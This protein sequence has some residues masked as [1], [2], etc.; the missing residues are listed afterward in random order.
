MFILKAFDCMGGIPFSQARAIVL[1]RRLL[2]DRHK[3]TLWR[4]NGV[5][6]AIDTFMNLL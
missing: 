5:V 1:Q 3:E 6:L 2:G 4:Q